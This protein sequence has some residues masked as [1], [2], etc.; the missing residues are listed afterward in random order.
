[1]KIKGNIFRTLGILIVLGVIVADRIILDEG[2]RVPLWIV[3]PSLVIAL[4]LI[5]IGVSINKNNNNPR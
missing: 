4:V 3:I 5:S 1:M 2:V